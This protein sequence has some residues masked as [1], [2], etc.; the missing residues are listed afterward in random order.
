MKLL[1]KIVVLIFSIILFFVIGH[2]I[3]LY[4]NP[5]YRSSIKL[6]TENK[7]VQDFRNSD[8]KV[9]LD[10]TLNLKISDQE[11]TTLKKDKES[12]ASNNSK[13]LD[14]EEDKGFQTIIDSANGKAYRLTIFTD[15]IL[16]ISELIRSKWNLVEEFKFDGYGSLLE[17]TDINFDSYPDLVISCF[18]DAYTNAYNTVLLFDPLN[19]KFTHSKE[20]DLINVQRGNK[21]G[22]IWSYRF[23][24]ASSSVWKELWYVDG[25]NN[26][27]FASGIEYTPTWNIK[28][29]PNDAGILT[30]YIREKKDRIDVKVIE[31]DTLNWKT[32][33]NE[34]YTF[35]E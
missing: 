29:F 12:R 10:D 27:K 8:V 21:K 1:T 22:E 23:G 31:D 15:S 16:Q 26:I 3:L 14:F 9:I 32:F 30:Y 35:K 2:Y 19:N 33:S 4:T 34:L 7:R 5:N 17:E 13:F 24:G 6:R 11:P 20:F 25:F 28:G 18:C